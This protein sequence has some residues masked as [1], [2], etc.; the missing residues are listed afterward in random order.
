MYKLS[1]DDI[2]YLPV[3]SDHKA[4]HHDDSQPK[5]EV[6]TVFQIFQQHLDIFGRPSKKFYS[7][8]AN[9]ATLPNEAEKLRWVV[10]DDQKA[11]EEFKKRVDETITYADI[12]REFPSAHPSVS[13]LLDLISPIKPRHYSIASSMRACP[14]SV[15]LLVV[16]EDWK[17]PSGKYREG[18]TS[19]YLSRLRPSTDTSPSG[20]TWLTVSV[21]PSL[22]K[23]PPKHTQP[24]IMAGLGTGMAPFRAF[25]QERAYWQS[26]GEKVGPMALYF[27]SRHRSQEYLY[28]EELEAYNTTAI[29]P[30]LRLAFSRDQ[31]Q[32]VYIQHKLLGD[33]DILHDMLLK[34][35]GHFYL[36][37]PTWPA[38][39]VYDAI[40]SSFVKGGTL[41][42][43]EAEKQVYLMKETSRY[44][45]EVY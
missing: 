14:T 27:G 24:V 12:L 30:Y 44:V 35:E 7:D 37:G 39:D 38:G 33:A 3:T 43:E 20:G 4:D 41:T 13:E 32:K 15:H 28:G 31:E 36:C 11:K 26:K 1:G 10:S 34:Q 16:V 22:M 42:K 45:L 19:S 17:S 25:I 21:A 8:L 29:L 6:R 2:V 18:H 40:V 9:F 5:F 23:L